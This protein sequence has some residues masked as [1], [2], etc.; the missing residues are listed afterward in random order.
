[1]GL[2]DRGRK[3]NDIEHCISTSKRI[4]HGLDCLAHP[5]QALS[6][7]QRETVA[8]T[9]GWQPPEDRNAET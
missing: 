5:P 3:Y 8:Q 2:N 7:T 6:K 9:A 4:D 1:M